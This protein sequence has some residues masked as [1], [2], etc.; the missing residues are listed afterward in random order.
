[1]SIATIVIHA[2][3]WGLKKPSRLPRSWHVTTAPQ[4]SE[5]SLRKQ[6]SLG[7]SMHE[8]CLN[9]NW[10]ARIGVLPFYQATNCQ[11]Y[12]DST[13]RTGFLIAREIRSGPT[14]QSATK[15]QDC[16]R[17]RFRSQ[18]SDNMERWKSRGGKS[19]RRE[20]KRRRLRRKK[21]QRRERVR[22]KRC[23]CAKR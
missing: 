2:C 14:K 13:K 23:R 19:Q 3:T 6:R 15:S 17:R 9:S 12:C 18:T 1:M 16:S 5:I 4:S 22:G 21:N 10:T 20:E 8:A 7:L 11:F